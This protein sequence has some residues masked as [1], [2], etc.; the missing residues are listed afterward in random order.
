M[1]VQKYVFLVS[2]SHFSWGMSEP[3]F[4]KM[5]HYDTMINAPCD[6]HAMHSNCDVPQSRLRLCL[7]GGVADT[8][9]IMTLSVTLTEEITTLSLVLFVALV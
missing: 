9:S 8:H 7:L 5:G 1:A 3:H 2:S 4:S 6:P